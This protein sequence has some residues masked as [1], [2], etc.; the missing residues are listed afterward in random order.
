MVST[1]ITSYLGEGLLAS[2]PSAPAIDASACAL[3][4][5]TDQA[6]GSQLSVY[7]AGAWTTT[8]GGYSAGTPPTVV[9]VAFAPNHSTGVTFGVAPTNGN[10]L[11]AF[12]WNPTVNTAGT[13]W[14]KQFEN[15]TG[16]D[17]GSIYSKVA[18]AGESTTQNPLNSAPA[19]GG[20]V[21]WEIHGQAASFFASAAAQGEQSGTQATPVLLPNVTK[22]LGLAGIGVVTTPTITTGLNA[23]TQDVL[24]NTG[25]RKLFAGH[26]DLSKTPMAGV[27]A[28]FST[29]ASSK[30]LTC[31]ITA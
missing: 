25:E 3:W 14:T 18:G 16:S 26:T 10:L 17:F 12:C 19:A 23:G 27:M 4:W 11:I 20:M 29:T 21:V 7:A 6:A 9:Q 1:L 13:G 2:R 30:A 24:D 5:A 8:G 22:C 15:S 28:T 31:L